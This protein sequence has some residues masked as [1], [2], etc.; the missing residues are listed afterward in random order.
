MIIHPLTS[1]KTELIRRASLCD[2]APFG[3]GWKHYTSM[4]IYS[5]IWAS[6]VF[7]NLV[8]F[9]VLVTYIN[10]PDLLVEFPQP[11]EIVILVLLLL[12]SFF[13]PYNPASLGYITID[14]IFIISVSF[15]I[16]AYKGW[17]PT[18]TYDLI[19]LLLN[20]RTIVAFLPLI[21]A[22]NIVLISFLLP[23]F[24]VMTRFVYPT[25]PIAIMLF[26][27]FFVSIH[28]LADTHNTVR[29]TFDV[30]LRTILLDIHP[31]GVTEYHPVAARI[32]YYLFGFAS[33]YLF[34][35][36]GI[37]GVGM[38]VAR[39]TDWH[40]E[41]VRLKAIKLLRYLPSRRPIRRKRLLGRGKV[42]SAMPFNILEGI[43]VVF[44]IYWLRDVAIY[45]GMLPII[46]EWSLESIA[47]T[48]LFFI[49]GWM[50]KL[51]GCILDEIETEIDSDAE[52]EDDLIETA[53][54]LS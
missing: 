11:F 24:N 12:P 3:R 27:G 6:H 47:R 37:A 19:A 18:P 32:L 21:Q 26:I 38:R 45:L 40:A 28:F 34:W 2:P 17:M 5:L 29:Y 22:A 51:G 4:L 16:A 25:F 52:V 49:W 43:G 35:G 30:L 50:R 14:V 1:G 33:L 46:L 54:L 15:R 44:R 53:P 39:E 8:L 7:Y 13:P 20:S 41:R 10:S 48:I 9:V 36:V 23:S 42:V 31:G